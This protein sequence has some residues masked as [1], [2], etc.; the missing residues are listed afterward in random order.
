MAY[1]DDLSPS[2]T[3][4]LVRNRRPVDRTRSPAEVTLTLTI[5]RRGS[6]NL[7]LR[8]RLRPKSSSA[9][10]LSALRTSRIT[11]TRPTRPK[12]IALDT[13]TSSSDCATT[14]PSRG[15]EQDALVALWQRVC[16]VAAHGLPLK[17][18]RLAAITKPSVTRRGCQWLG[19]MWGRSLRSHSPGS[20]PRMPFAP[21]P[22]R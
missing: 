17:C 11:S 14:R 20:H 12:G 19:N 9:V 1:S 16:A 15:L 21:L 5:A 8:E 2:C 4:R 10:S 6:M 18:C 22:S 3:P 13:R 7:A